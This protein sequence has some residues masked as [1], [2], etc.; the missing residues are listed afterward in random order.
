MSKEV[1][2]DLPKIK[3]RIIDEE[4]AK[5]AKIEVI[6]VNKD[7][8]FLCIN[9]RDIPKG[10]CCIAEYIEMILDTGIVIVDRREEK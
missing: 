1:I 3:W 10:V 8:A 2:T 9:L 4:K 6:N 7:T 5:E